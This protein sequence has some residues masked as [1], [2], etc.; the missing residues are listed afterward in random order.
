SILFYRSIADRNFEEWRRVRTNGAASLLADSFHVDARRLSHRAMHKVRRFGQAT[1]FVQ[2]TVV[3]LALLGLM[4]LNHVIIHDRWRAVAAL[5][6]AYTV[7]PGIDFAYQR[8]L[9]FPGVGQEYAGPFQKTGD[10]DRPS[11]Q[12]ER[13]LRARARWFLTPFFFFAPYFVVS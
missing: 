5:L 9:N 12:P 8:G 13:R 7:L 1:A 2:F 11:V 4:R 3:S 6:I 10:L